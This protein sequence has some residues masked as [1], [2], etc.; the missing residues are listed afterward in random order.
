MDINEIQ[1]YLNE[2]YLDLRLNTQHKSMPVE[3]PDVIEIIGR[4][5]YGFFV[6]EHGA[7]TGVIDARVKEHLG[8]LIDLAQHSLDMLKIKTG[9]KQEILG[10]QAVLVEGGEYW[11]SETDYVTLLN[12]GGEGSQSAA[13]MEFGGKPIKYHMLLS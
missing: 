3:V 9:I 10:V 8:H 5:Q 13:S 2:Q 11:V 1:E 12:Q 6:E 7:S 4:I